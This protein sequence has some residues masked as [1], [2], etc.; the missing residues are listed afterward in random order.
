MKC[1]GEYPPADL[2]ARSTDDTPPRQWP[3]A[4]AWDRADALSSH[5][6][7]AFV[8]AF[9]ANHRPHQRHLIHHLGSLRQAG[10]N[11]DALG[12]RTDGFCAA[13]NFLRMRSKA[14][15]WLGPPPIKHDDGFG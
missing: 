6:G 3:D 13:G 9:A 4:P 5:G 7:A 1:V 10:G 8:I 2:L 12:G 15:S 14:S 11:L